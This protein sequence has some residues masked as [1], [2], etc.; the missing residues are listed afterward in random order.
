MDKVCDIISIVNM[1][2]NKHAKLLIMKTYIVIKIQNTK[3][4]FLFSYNKHNK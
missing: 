4:I 1:V 3:I 2:N